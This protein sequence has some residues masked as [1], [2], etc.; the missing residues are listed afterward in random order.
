VAGDVV[1][2]VRD[3]GIGI[4][5]DL[6]PHVFDMFT[7]GDRAREQ[8][9]GGLGVGLTLVRSLVQLHGGSVEVH[10]AGPGRGSEFVVRLP[11]A[12]GPPEAGTGASPRPGTMAL[13]PK[14]ILVVDDNHDQVESLGALLTL[15]GHEVRLAENGPDA[16]QVAADFGPDLAL[17]DI[18]LPGLSGYEVA[19]RLR[20]QPRFRDLLLV[21]QT[22]WGQDD[23]R[24]RSREAGFDH[25]LVKPIDVEAIEELLRSLRPDK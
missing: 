19:R 3:T 11:L 1:L 13:A 16:L 7:Q 17:V 24:R 20:E 10:S 9:R 23:D 14:R 25:H 5:A 4:P 15:K 18:G 6:R 2:R 22:G 21:A 12:E 8:S